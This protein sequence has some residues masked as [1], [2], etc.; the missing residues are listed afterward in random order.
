MRSRTSR[1]GWLPGFVSTSARPV[2][3]ER[4]SSSSARSRNPLIAQ[5]VT[6]EGDSLKVHDFAAHF[7]FSFASR[8]AGA[9]EGCLK[10]APNL[11]AFRAAVDDF[12]ALRD[13]LAEGRFGGQAVSTA[14]PLNV[15]PGL[16][17]A[18]RK[19]V[20]DAIVALLEKHLSPFQ[21][22][23]MAIMGLPAGEGLWNFVPMQNTAAG[24]VAVPNYPWMAR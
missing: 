9:P 2:F 6:G 10:F 15:H 12:V 16:S 14:G 3:P 21:L 17:G 7:I 23:S 24:P 20:R 18:S 11:P 8:D 13:G 5:P 1:A 19:Q 22:G 4:S